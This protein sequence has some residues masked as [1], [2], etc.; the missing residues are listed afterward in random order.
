MSF[1]LLGE[2]SEIYRH[3]GTANFIKGINTKVSI[4]A[5]ITKTLVD[6]SNRKSLIS[7]KYLYEIVLIS[8]SVHN[9]SVTDSWLE[10]TRIILNGM[11]TSAKTYPNGFT[12]LVKQTPTVIY[13]LEMD[14]ENPNISLR[15]NEAKYEPVK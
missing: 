12:V 11:E 8:H 3:F 9:G 14:S 10:G 5:Y 4:E 1:V 2:D 13:W 6:D 15:W 7:Y